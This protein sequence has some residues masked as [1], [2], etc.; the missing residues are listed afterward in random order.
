[1]KR[2]YLLSGLIIMVAAA[3][4]LSGCGEKDPGALGPSGV[5]GGLSQEG[6]AEEYTDGVGRALQQLG[7]SQ[8]ESFGKAIESGNS[9]QLQAANIAWNQ[10]LEQ[11]RQ[12]DPPKEAL[13][14]HKQLVASVEA[15]AKWNERIAKA[16]PNKA[17]T[18]KLGRQAS[19]SP[20]SKQFEAAVCA[21]VDAGYEVIDSGAC[22]PLANADGPVE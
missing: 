11:L 8:G 16:A 15:L 14:A 2:I 6:K 18:R 7:S 4:V 19:A 22:T 12:I 9:R 17:L 21:V 5:G 10:G 3:I 20:A 13:G 1:M